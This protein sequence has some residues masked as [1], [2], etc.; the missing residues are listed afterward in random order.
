LEV[1]SE[2]EE[3]LLTEEQIAEDGDEGA[4]EIY[5]PLEGEAQQLVTTRV[6]RAFVDM[7]RPV[8][9]RSTDGV[10]KTHTCWQVPIYPSP[11]S[12]AVVTRLLENHH[13]PYHEALDR[14]GEGVVLGLDCHT[15][16]AVGPPIGPDHGVERPPV[17]LGNVRGQSCPDAILNQLARCMRDALGVEVALNVPFSGG[18]ITKRRPGGIPWIQI[19]LSRG[20]WATHEQ[21]SAGMRAALTALAAS[22]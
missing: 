11:L 10:V 6:A 21:K 1:P 17:C 14:E 2:I 20:D 13:R 8:D 3:H 12:E 19:E 18:Y 4:A 5:L 7:N 16:A 15:M 22:L 9:D